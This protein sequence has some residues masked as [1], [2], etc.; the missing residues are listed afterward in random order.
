MFKELPRLR[1]ETKMSR[2]K[3]K[4]PTEYLSQ[5][6]M[7]PDWEGEC[8]ACGAKPTVSITGLCGPC[9]FGEADTLNGNW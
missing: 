5:E 1:E 9:S 4:E 7:E 6:E 8:E 2:N 3:K